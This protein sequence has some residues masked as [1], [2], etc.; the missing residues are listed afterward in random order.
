MPRIL[1]GY[2]LPRSLTVIVF[3]LSWAA[4]SA[5]LCRLGERVFP[6][7]NFGLCTLLSFSAQT[8]LRTSYTDP[9]PDRR[10]IVL[11]MQLCSLMDSSKRSNKVHWHVLL[12]VTRGTI[13]VRLLRDILSETQLQWDRSLGLIDYLDIYQYVLHSRPKPNKKQHDE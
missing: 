13:R 10:R 2:P 12:Q 11:C 1:T 8:T 7:R 4:S 3:A 9:S 5:Y 6:H